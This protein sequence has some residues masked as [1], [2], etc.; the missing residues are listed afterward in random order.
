MISPCSRWFQFVP[1]SSSLFQLV[2]GSSISFQLVPRFSMYSTRHVRR[3]SPI[4]VG[5][6][7][8]ITWLYFHE[9]KSYWMNIKFLNEYNI[10]EWNQNFWMKLYEMNRK[11]YWM[12]L[13]HKHPVFKYK[14]KVFEWKNNNW[15]KLFNELNINMKLL[16]ENRNIGYKW[17]RTEF[18]YISADL[19]TLIEKLLRIWKC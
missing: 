2:P 11:H 17:T 12:S 7:H 18:C 8:A 16:N 10:F 9:L 4:I 19:L 13:L 1:G 5:W 6:N 14:I 15:M 3:L